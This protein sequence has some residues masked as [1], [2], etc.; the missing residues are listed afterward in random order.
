MT[1]HP[2]RPARKMPLADQIFAD[3]IRAYAYN[4]GFDAG[5]L[6]GKSDATAATDR[7]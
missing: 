5:Y 3:E 7:R 2:T 6:R 4:D 1:D